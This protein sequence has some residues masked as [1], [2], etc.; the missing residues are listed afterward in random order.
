[1]LSGLFGSRLRE[2]ILLFIWK[3]G[4]TYA[5]EFMKY[6]EANVYAVQKQLRHLEE[7]GVLVSFIVSGMTGII[8]GMYPAMRAA[9]VATRPGTSPNPSSRS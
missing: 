8:F 6:F 7:L 4:D 9:S 2:K 1:M 3:A 5:Y